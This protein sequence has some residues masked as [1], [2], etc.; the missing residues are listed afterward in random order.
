MFF[1]DMPMPLSLTQIS[2][3]SWYSLSAKGKLCTGQ[4]PDSVPTVLRDTRRACAVGAEFDGVREQVIDD[5]LGL[6][7]VQLWHAE[8]I[9]RL[10]IELDALG[11]GFFPDDRQAVRKQLVQIDRLEFE[12]HHAC[13][14]LRQIQDVVD[15]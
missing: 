4:L 10:E 11:C 2:R 3:N 13:L 9:A 15:Q 12:R 5:L 8:V 7:H 14:D 6:A 1:F